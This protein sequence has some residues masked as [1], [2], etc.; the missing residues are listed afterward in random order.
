MKTLDALL[1]NPGPEELY[2]IAEVL[3]AAERRPDQAAAAEL[4]PD[5]DV[6][7]VSIAWDELETLALRPGLGRRLRRFVDHGAFSF[8]LSALGAAAPPTCVW[9]LARMAQAFG[10]DEALEVRLGWLGLSLGV[11]VAALLIAATAVSFFRHHHHRGYRLLPLG[12]G[13]LSALVTAG[14]AGALLRVDLPLADII[15]TVPILLACLASAAAL[16]AFQAGFRSNALRT[17]GAAALGTAAV[18]A[19]IWIDLPAGR[20]VPVYDPSVAMLQPE[21]RVLLQRIEE[22]LRVQLAEEYRQRE[23]VAGHLQRLS[24]QVAQGDLDRDELIAGL[25]SISGE[26]TERPEASAAVSA[27]LTTMLRTLGY[28]E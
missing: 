11:V 6:P 3:R 15:C 28:I 18:T 14:S 12:F 27:E 22:E 20:T 17:V 4:S 7:V 21:A 9:T 19:F 26:L 16:L 2:D 1:E 25:D 24:T 23:Q 10:E 5:D 13:L 8:L